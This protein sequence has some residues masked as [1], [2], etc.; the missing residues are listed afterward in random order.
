MTTSTD[1]TQAP[2]PNISEFA[3]SSQAKTIEEQYEELRKRAS[4][5]QSTATKAI[6]DRTKLE[7]A[8]AGVHQTLNDVDA[9]YAAAKAAIADKEN[10]IADL[11]SIAEAKAM[12]TSRLRTISSE[13]PDLLPFITAEADLLPVS[14]DL[15]DLR[16]KLNAFRSVKGNQK[17]ADEVRPQSPQ[18]PPGGGPL[19]ANESKSSLRQ[20][21]ND[22]F[23]TNDRTEYNRLYTL[24]LQQ[25][26]GQ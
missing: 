18:S 16:K 22:A 17:P 6:Q 19:P 11:K 8:L 9:R 15:D 2:T 12:E 25:P 24:W 21:M 14:S 7:E 26:Q 3:P 20:K 10:E 13:F 5:W 1:T 23:R 4:G